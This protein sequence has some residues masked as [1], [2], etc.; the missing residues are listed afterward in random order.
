[1]Q[2]Q[3]LGTKI[4]YG[5]EIQLKHIFTGK[6]LTIDPYA[7]SNYHGAVSVSIKGLS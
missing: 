3:R 5:E 1:M 2:K 6:Y 7:M 4:Q